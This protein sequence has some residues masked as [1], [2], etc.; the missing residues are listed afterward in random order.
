M[1][2]KPVPPQGGKRLR[3]ESRVI[4]DGSQTLTVKEIP[5]YQFESRVILD[6]SQTSAL[7]GAHIGVFESRV[8]LDGSQTEQLSRRGQPQV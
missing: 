7:S 3:F 5:Y 6:G 8:I 2:V 4:L 1:V